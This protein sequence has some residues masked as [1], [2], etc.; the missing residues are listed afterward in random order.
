MGKPLMI[1]ES[2]DRRIESLKKKIGVKTKVE[3]VRRALE[4]LEERAERVARI[5]QW[6][7]AARLAAKSSYEVLSDFKPHSRLKRND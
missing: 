1:Q 7:K 4:L 5:S 2:D 3:V 6:K